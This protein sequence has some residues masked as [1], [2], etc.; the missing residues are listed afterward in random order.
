[1]QGPQSPSWADETIWWQVY[2]LGFT[3][4]PTAPADAAP[5][6]AP[7]GHRL[8]QLEH[9]LDYAADL[10]CS[11][12]LL[13]PIFAS[14]THGYD[15]T[16]HFRIDPR[17]GN[18]QD[19]DRL[20]AA[21]RQRRLRI[22]LDGVFNHV[23]RGFAAFAE[24]L[25]AGPD[26][27][28]AR[29]FLPNRREDG[30]VSYAT[31]EGHDQL[32]TL[33]H[34]E[35]AVAAYVA[36]V[37][38]HWLDRGGSGWRLDAAYAVPPAFWR[39]VLP[40]VRDRHPAAWFT[41]EIIHGDYARYA[42]D[43]SIDSVTQYELWKAIWSSLNDRNFFELAWAL[44]RHDGFLD[45]LTPL[46]FIGN[47]DVTR[48]ASRLSDDRHLGHALAVLFSV[49]G[50]PAVYYGDEQALRGVKEDRAGGD[51]AIRP[52]YPADPGQLPEAGW[53]VYRLHQ[54]LIGMRRRHPWLA[55][56]RTTVAHLTNR[57]LALQA[58]ADDG[59]RVITLLN[60]DDRPQE[61]PIDLSGL[62]ATENLGAETEEDETGALPAHAWRIIVAEPVPG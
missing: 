22:V 11:G 50:T 38:N 28:A 4:A 41:A 21:A 13:G 51:D 40:A 46:T 48:I 16:D 26:S 37:M 57:A 35:P 12:L 33:N 23:G 19:F 58:C 24:A 6:E 45:A 5:D 36:A 25:A 30:S 10:G 34:A 62:V 49:A 47:H 18:D 54:Q 52:A 27:A 42:A 59:T 53:P 17:L 3:G 1:M 29:W 8:R 44:G 55:R 31:F 2:P 32:V 61:L 7:V 15:T 60:V 9:W 14:Q 43:S 56:A 20:V 39:E